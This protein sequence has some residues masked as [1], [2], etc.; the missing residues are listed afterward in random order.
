M[1]DHLRIHPF[2]LSSCRFDWI[3]ANLE[4]SH[5]PSIY[6]VW[7]CF[8]L[9]SSVSNLLIRYVMG[10]LFSEILSYLVDFGSRILDNPHKAKCLHLHFLQLSPQSRTIDRQQTCSCRNVSISLVHC[11]L[12]CRLFSFSQCLHR[13]CLLYIL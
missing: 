7:G 10:T 3:N 4:A 1:H 8:Y 13:C 12:N 2:N 11:T 6:L 9:N 5:S